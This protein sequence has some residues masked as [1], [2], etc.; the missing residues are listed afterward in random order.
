MTSKNRIKLADMKNDLWHLKIREK[1]LTESVI[2]LERQS[3]VS[4]LQLRISELETDHKRYV[5]QFDRLAEK[6]EDLIEFLEVTIEKQYGYKV[7]V[8]KEKM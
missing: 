2:K 7:I 3:D 8:K 5:L 4:K 1:S 6:F